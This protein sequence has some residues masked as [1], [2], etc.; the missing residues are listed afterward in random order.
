MSYRTRLRLLTGKFFTAPA[1]ARTTTPHSE[2]NRKLRDSAA[3]TNA[4]SS[5][6]ANSLRVLDKLA[7]RAIVQRS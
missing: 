6:A 4:I 2:V 3:D 1:H 5:Y 7:V